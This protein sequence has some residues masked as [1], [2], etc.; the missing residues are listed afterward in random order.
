MFNIWKQFHH[1][2][3][4]DETIARCWHGGPDG[5]KGDKNMGYWYQIKKRL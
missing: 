5:D 2:N 1:E 3:D 4:S